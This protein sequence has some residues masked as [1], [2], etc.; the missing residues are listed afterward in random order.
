VLRFVFDTNKLDDELA[1]KGLTLT[2]KTTLET[3]VQGIA[4]DVESNR[5]ILQDIF[6]EAKKIREKIDSDNDYIETQIFQGKVPSNLQ[7]DKD[8]NNAGLKAGDFKK[9][10]DMKTNLLLAQTD[11]A[12][13]RVE[14]K[15]EHLAGEKQFESARAELVRDSLTGM[16]A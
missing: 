16:Q 12:K 1:K 4:S 13:E 7:Y 11:E 5:A 8:G 14:D 2:T 10:V 3:R 9:L 6:S 15:I